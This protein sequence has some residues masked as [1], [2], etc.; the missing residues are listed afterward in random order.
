MG[1]QKSEIG[2]PTKYNDEMLQRCIKYANGG[3]EQEGD[4][5]P[6]MA[7]LSVALGVVTSTLYE[8]VKK[9]PQFSNMFA[10]LM[11]N[12]QRILLNGGMSGQFNSTITKLVL[13]KHGY[14]DRVEQ[15]I[16]H[17]TTETVQP[18]TFQGV[19]KDITPKVK[20][21][22]DSPKHG[23]ARTPKPDTI[24]TVETVA[25]EHVPDTRDTFKQAT[26]QHMGRPVVARD[27]GAL[28]KRRQRKG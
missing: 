6:S 4:I 23:W 12:Q 10:D 19:G 11:A 25:I 8:W 17:R 26:S 20:Q 5:I 27:A 3:Y 13:S 18:A 16:D 24:E 1:T 21:V 9:Y 14:S 15:V 22:G 28:A 7:G 2:R